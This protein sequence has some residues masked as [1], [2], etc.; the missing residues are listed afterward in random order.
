DRLRRV[1]EPALR[2][3]LLPHPAPFDGMELDAP[4]LPTGHLAPQA[5]P[6]VERGP[7]GHRLLLGRRLGG[8]RTG[9][10]A[11]TKQP[12]P[13]LARPGRAQAR[14]EL[15]RCPHGRLRAPAPAAPGAA[16]PRRTRS[17]A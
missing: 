11:A 8:E 10:R 14:Q 12:V 15:L 3:H 5:Q 1:E 2:E 16:A 4:L 9:P 13:A 6:A 7:V 17:A